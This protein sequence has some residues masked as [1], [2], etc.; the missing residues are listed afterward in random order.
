[1]DSPNRTFSD[2]VGLVKSWIPWRSEPVNVS[3]DFWMPDES[4]RL[5]YDCE[6]QFTLFNRRHHCRLC[7]RVFCSKCTSNWIPMLSSQQNIS[8]E[9]WDK[10][11][12]CNFCFKL[13]EQGMTAPAEN[14]TQLADLDLGS[15]SPSAASFI[16][17]MSSTC[18]SSSMTF[19]SLPKSVGLTQYQSSAPTE[20]QSIAAPI[21]NDHDVGMGEQTLS[22][23]QLKFFPCRLLTHAYWI[24]INIGFE[25]GILFDSFRIAV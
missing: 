24:L 1:M 12:V 11:R 20:R 13:W 3:R 17:T 25:P 16:S 7:G 4:C 15:S 8:P 2:V 22:L 9:D 19:V 6:S 23:D 5:C 21:N 14:G 10:I 18:C